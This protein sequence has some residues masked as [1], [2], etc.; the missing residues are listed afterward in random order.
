MVYMIYILGAG[1]I[2]IAQICSHRNTILIQVAKTLCAA[3]E[4]SAV[5]SPGKQ[6]IVKNDLSKYKIQKEACIQ[7]LSL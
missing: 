4:R 7:H 1:R 2:C 5:E 6:L 3:Y